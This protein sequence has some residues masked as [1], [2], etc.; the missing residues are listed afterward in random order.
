MI[1]NLRSAPRKP[2]VPSWSCFQRKGGT[3]IKVEA[4]QQFKTS[5]YVLSMIYINIYIFFLQ[6]QK[7]AE[8]AN[9]P[10]SIFFFSH[11]KSLE[12]IGDNRACFYFGG[13][14]LCSSHFQICI[15]YCYQK[16]MMLIQEWW[17]INESTANEAS[18]VIFQ[19]TFFCHC[20]YYP[21]SLGAFR[22]LQ[23]CIC[24]I[25]SQV[26]D[27]KKLDKIQLRLFNMLLSIQSPESF[28]IFFFHCKH[29][30]SF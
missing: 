9:K 28:L 11:H 14:P 25:A 15:I 2:V 5:N 19:R 18:V 30:Y 13:V 26:Y 23:A 21:Q 22:F 10:M 29:I 1:L 27:F 3:D 6:I 20:W 24:T 7:Y 8:Y 17:I 16:R 12:E 4:K